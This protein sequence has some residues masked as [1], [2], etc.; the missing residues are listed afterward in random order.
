MF[1]S[2]KLTL[3]QLYVK[4][5]Y[6]IQGFQ[7]IFHERKNPN[8]VLRMVCLIKEE[9]AN[10]LEIRFDL[11]DCEFPSIWIEVKNENQKPTLVAGYYREWTQ[12]GDNSLSEP[13]QFKH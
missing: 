1:S 4:L 10:N 13:Y 6:K 8:D 7:T 2:P 9:I 11:M 12:N 3:K 5:T